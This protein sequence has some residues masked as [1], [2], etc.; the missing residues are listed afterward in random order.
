M[1]AFLAKLAAIFSVEMIKRILEPLIQWLIN[2]A[3]RKQQEARDEKA[4]QEVLE[5]VQKA[6]TNEERIEAARRSARNI[7]N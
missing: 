7:A 3:A 6:Q 1:E 5:Q 2:L 4:T